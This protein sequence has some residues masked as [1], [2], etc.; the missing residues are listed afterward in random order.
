MG[1]VVPDSVLRMLL[2]AQPLRTDHSINVEGDDES[3]KLSSADLLIGT[4][5]VEER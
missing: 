4:A 2:A 1:V 5:A 3:W